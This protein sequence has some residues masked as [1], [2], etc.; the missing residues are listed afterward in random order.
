LRKGIHVPALRRGITGF[1]VFIEIA[2]RYMLLQQ[3]LIS[4]QFS[5]K[6]S[7]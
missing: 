7:V 1:K 2:V 3:T 4:Q 5:E 6:V